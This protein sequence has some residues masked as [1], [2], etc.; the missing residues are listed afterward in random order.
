M[1]KLRLLAAAVGAAAALSAQAAPVAFNGHWYEYFGD[2]VTAQNAFAL[3][4]ASNFNGMQGYLVTVTDA[5]ENAFVANLAQGQLAWMGG[6][7]DGD[8]VNSWTWRVGPEAGQAFTYTNWNAGEPNDCC[9][10]E[11]YVHINWGGLGLWNDHGGPGN[12]GQ[13]NGYVVEYSASAVPE[14]MTLALVG[15]GLVG[16]AAARRRRV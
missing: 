4:G 15:L 13:I 5:A 9:G 6:S 1:N 2:A 10:G 14:P 11:N 16:A 8:A 3:A 12:P 7:D